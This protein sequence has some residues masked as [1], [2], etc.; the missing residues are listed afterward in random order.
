M[1]MDLDLGIC[2]GCR[3]NDVAIKFEK[4]KKLLVTRDYN[5][6]TAILKDLINSPYK[7]DSHFFYL[8][9]ALLKGKKPFLHDR[10]V[11]S[12]VTR[13]IN[14]AINI[15]ELPVYHYFMAYVKYD[16]FARKRYAITPGYTESLKSAYILGLTEEDVNKLHILLSTDRPDFI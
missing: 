13:S 12:E 10:G 6:A 8:A 3:E 2:N 9:I 7:K 15:N 1:H 14:A 5:E 11:I 4:A 16:F